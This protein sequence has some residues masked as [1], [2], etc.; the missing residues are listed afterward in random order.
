MHE[1]KKKELQKFLCREFVPEDCKLTPVSLPCY[2]L[3][4]ETAA[5]LEYPPYLPINNLK[6]MYW[7]YG[8]LVGRYQYA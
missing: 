2:P 3:V 8:R 1:I 4:A 6:I 5:F 7:Y